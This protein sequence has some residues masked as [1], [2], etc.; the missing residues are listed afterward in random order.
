MFDSFRRYQRIL[1]GVVLL[2][3]IPSFI[4]VGAWD[5]VSPAG[6][7][8]TV[9]KVGKQN[10]QYPQ[11]ERSHQQ[12]LE[13]IRRQFGGRVDTALFDTPAARLGTLEELISQQVLLQ[14]VQDLKLRIPDEQLRDTIARIP[15]IQ[16]DG[17]FDLSLYQQALRAQGMTPEQFEQ[18]VRAELAV[19]FLPNRIA[20]SSL[21]P[22]VMARRLAQ[23]AHET[24]TVRT[25]RL[26]AAA[27]ASA[28]EVSDQDIEAFYQANQSRFQTKD[29]VD[30]ALVRLAG[31]LEAAEEFA[32]IVYEQSDTLEPAAKKF[33]LTISE[34]RGIQRS[35]PTADLRPELREAL[36][37]GR[38][39]TALFGSES[40]LSRRNTEAVEVAPGVFVSAR[41]TAHRSAAALP[42]DA[43][44]VQIARE[45]R[46]D[47]ARQAASDRARTVYQALA[48]D[49][50]DTSL[51]RPRVISRAKQ[52][53]EKE[54]PQAVLEAIFSAAPEGFPH[55]LTVNASPRDPSAWVVV[56][57][58]AQ[59]PAVT[60]ADVTRVLGQAF[61]SLEAAHAQDIL[62]KWLSLRRQET[63]VKVFPERLAIRDGR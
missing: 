41:V 3:I 15:Q 8:A 48:G 26:P 40:I 44:R 7:A 31:G 4:I 42:L 61:Q 36:T 49:M 20:M 10:I 38:L 28:I 2:L 39:L 16:K 51:S 17:Q 6:N 12:A 56:I 18:Q 27:Y 45:L 9:A 13:Q 23:A 22:R 37:N 25:L 50:V 5:L 53:D 58:Q 54:L 19:E 11:W 57:D 59:V 24:R 34:A 46:D 52:A 43:V 33:G 32:N 55:K 14:S 35:G 60:Q 47:R 1:L 30:I 29:E 62:L 21:G 63:G